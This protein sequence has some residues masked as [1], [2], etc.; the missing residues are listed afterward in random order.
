M[1]GRDWFSVCNQPVKLPPWVKKS[2]WKVKNKISLFQ[3]GLLNLTAP[4]YRQSLQHLWE[5]IYT[6]NINQRLKKSVFA[7][8]YIECQYINYMYNSEP[9]L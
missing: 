7:L 2:A 8:L 6:L 5:Q 1:L 9:K 3:A 4:V